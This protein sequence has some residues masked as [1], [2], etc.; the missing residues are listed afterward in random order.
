VYGTGTVA[1]LAQLYNSAIG[2][3][4]SMNV[5]ARALFNGTNWSALVEAP[6]TVDSLLPTLRITEIMYNPIGGD[7]YEF[8]E[9][10]NTGPIP[11]NIG[12]YS[13]GG[14]S[15][16]F[17]FGYTL[18]AGQRIVLGN[19]GNT[20]L[21]NA[22]YPGVVVAG[23]F[24]GSLNN[25]GETITIFDAT[26]PTPRIVLTV[27]YDDEGG[28]PA[29]AD[30]GGY[31]L[32]ITDANADPDDMANW[33]ASSGQNGTPGQVNSAVP[34]ATVLFNELMADNV[35]AVIHESTYP[36]WLELFNPTGGAINLAN[37]S[38]SDD[39]NTRKFVFPGGTT[40]GAGGY[41]VVWCDATTNTT[42]GLHAGFALGR[43]GDTVS[44][45]DGNSTRIDAISY[46]LQI[47]NY[48]VGRIGGSWTLTT[49]T[50]NA[51]NVA[52]TLA[53][54]SA[55]SINEWLV[56]SAPG[57]DDWLELFNTS[58]SAPV[59]LRNIYLG[60]SNALFQLRPLSF[61][62][63][64]GYQ[65]F[66]ADELPG[67]D[68][69]DFKLPANLGA[70]VLYDAA[71]AE[72]QRVTYGLQVQ[73]VSQGRLP[74]GTATITAFPGSASP[75][76]TNYAN[77]YTGPALNEVLA[78]NSGAV[79]GPWGNYP[80]FLE[81]YNPS[82]TNF[83]LGGMG[84]SD[85]S[86]KVKFVFAP[87]TTIV[88]N[89]YLVVWCDGGRSANTNGTLNSG[90]SLSSSSGGAYLFNTAGQLVNSV[91][92]GFQVEDLPIGLSGGQWRLLSSVTPGT[93]NS[94]TNALGSVANLRVN[95]WMA[96]P[97]GGNDW[98][99]LYNLDPLPVSLSGLYLT[100][101]LSLAGLSNTPIAALSFIAGNGW[102][103]WIADEDPS[104]GRAHARFDLD[105]DADNIRLYAANFSII[106]SVSFAAQLDGVSQGRLPDGGTNVVSFP[107]TP[108][109]DASNYLPLSDVVINE[110]LTHTDPPLED[111]IEI[112]NAGTNTI[113]IG[114]WFISNSEKV[115]K[116]FRLAAGT[117]LTSGAFKVF[118]ETN[119]NAG[120]NGTNF[121]LNSAHGDSVYLSQTDGSGNLTGY[122]A[123]VSFGAAENGVSFGRFPTSAGVDFVAMAQRTF[124]VDNPATVA[125][126]RTG[127]GL[128]NSY[129]KIGPIIINEIMYHPSSGIGSNAVEL[130]SEE[131]IEL[132]N[133][134][135]S[136]VPM[137]DPAHPTNAWQ[138]SGG[139][140]FTFSSNITVA[141]QGYLVLVSFNP[142]TNA[143]AV[144][145]FQAKYGS[146]GTL[147]G[148]FQGRLGNGGDDLALSRP[149]APQQ[150]PH[151]DA[152]FVP[153]ILVDR[154]AY[155]D[156]APWPLAADGGGASLQRLAD[157]LY[158]NEPL[159]WK[160]EPATS[161]ATNTPGGVVA[162]TISSQ[163]T[164]LT[165]IAGSTATFS[166]GANGS[167]PLS[168]QWQHANT[169]LPGANSATLAILNAQ[170]SDA[171][172]YHVIVTNLGGNITS[173]DAVL[174]VL[175]PPFISAQPTN[176][177]AIAGNTVQFTVTAGGTA[178]LHYQWRLNGAELDSQNNAQLTLNSVQPV[179]AGNYTVV[180]TNVAGSIT[181][182]VA[183][184]IVNVPPFITSDPTN[185][186]VLDGGSVTF[187]VSAT[188]TAPLSYQWRKD[189]INIPG[190]NGL[191]YT[192]NPVSAGDEGLYSVF[193]TNVAG[194]ALSLAAQLTVS[195]QPFLANPHLRP[196]G[197]FEFTLV[198]RTNRTYSI[199]WT[200]D[201]NGWTNLTN[202]TLT[203]PQA[204]V[205]NP[206]TNAAARFYRAR[207]E[208]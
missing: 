48:S 17:P 134:T 99:E 129:P 144:A 142:A 115:L 200:P 97:T 81:I 118:Y 120:G 32:E 179:S 75:G 177:T 65:Q 41:L 28:W 19:N 143:A 192:I 206:S 148:P 158:G 181:S 157:S 78:R 197:V 147:A 79:P 20:N 139:A 149:D 6:F 103:K 50:T 18:N 164:N 83:N 167:V 70:I 98:F 21:F 163:P 80:D 8:L 61:L 91:E 51:P 38:L 165:L 133:V 39:G 161:G 124:G 74:D 170:A 184:L 2:L 121:T 196:D 72:L 30:G 198:G 9:L 7:V 125:Q 33:H 128:S 63:P 119:F 40:I 138:L 168:Y 90:F 137:F 24:G 60:T 117:T 160:A 3:S 150:A 171:G 112:Q 85:D 66:I 145:A 123:Q 110:V 189:S 109:P 127:I 122:R 12:N 82:P 130:A 195:S 5:K 25:G 71:G 14:I 186:T 16:T 35:S 47:A 95:E 86:G 193:V 190:A 114:D 166:V 44:L 104:Q 46:G 207:L 136:S 100:D 96:N 146:S 132:H 169:N 88:S 22:R 111:A 10:Q 1:P 180:I 56:D 155:G 106:D 53:P 101:D 29:S 140:S 178:P 202:I 26:V 15:F 34:A 153:M 205:T 73:G 93:T 43:N 68:H 208:P 49:P 77:I 113:D 59:A 13:F 87:G 52:A 107:N 31:S 23:W 174:T 151:P 37:W 154:V 188:G 62:P 203:S 201:F 152:G 102:V 141:A 182:A 67:V 183:V 4:Q 84:L 64:L 55:L 94:A 176:V 76:T 58:G 187:V 89:G 204:P 11:L 108:T 105:K 135:G 191:S 194:Q 172:F 156:T 42:S 199:D 54:A 27:T 185:Q 92:Y 159:N 57:A 131:F 126:F 162:P 116:K 175:V 173:Q 69:L 45:Y 36:D